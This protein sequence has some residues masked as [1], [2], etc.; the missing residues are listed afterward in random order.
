M[1]VMGNNEAF[2]IEGLSG[3][4]VL[5]GRLR[6][7]GAKNAALPAMA[8]AILF[9]DELRLNNVPNID[10]VAKAQELLAGI[11]FDIEENE[12]EIKITPPPQP[13]SKELNREIAKCLR[14]SI[15]FTGPILAR[16]GE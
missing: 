7:N 2:L 11:G 13:K 12:R 10:D 16:Y 6:V 8:S 9:K 14:A 15:I 5:S 1:L 3:E 4:R